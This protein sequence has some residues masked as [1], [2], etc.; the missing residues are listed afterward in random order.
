MIS[1]LPA[2]E[3]SKVGHATLAVRFG[4]RQKATQTE[5]EADGEGGTTVPVTTHIDHT[6]FSRGHACTKREEGRGEQVN[7]DSSRHGDRRSNSGSC[8]NFAAT[9]PTDDNITGT[10]VTVSMTEVV[11]QR[12]Q[13]QRQRQRRRYSN[14]SEQRHPQQQAERHQQR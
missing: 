12:H 11:S 6:G 3:A 5:V 2:G 4:G 10:V 13:R 1:T 9:A 8:Y 14:D 7:E